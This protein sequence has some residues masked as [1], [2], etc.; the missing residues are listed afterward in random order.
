MIKNICI[1]PARGGSKRIPNKNI[2]NLNGKPMI[3]YTIEAAIAS[4]L[5]ERIIVSTDNKRIAKI[6]KQYGAEVPFLREAYSDDYSP[7]SMATLNTL[8]QAKKYYNE[9]YDNVIQLF[10]TCPLR[11]SDHI[12]SAYKNFK[13]K[14][15]TFQISAFKLGWM[16]PWWAIKINENGEPE[17]LFVKEL[18]SR[19]QDLPDLYSPTGAVWIANAEAFEKE[20]TFYGK[21]YR[22]YELNWMNAVD[23]DDNDDLNMV[24]VIL[25]FNEER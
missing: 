5:F 7:V 19:S 10:A 18:K 8:K 1:I 22:L 2:I 24:K 9:K 14:G 16:N 13:D 4:K 3:A 12:I 23:V 20:K 15:N 21:D 6:S 11:N 17:Q 25:G